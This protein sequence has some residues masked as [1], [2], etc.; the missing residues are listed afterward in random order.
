MVSVFSLLYNF[1]SFLI[2]I[3]STE[4]KMMVDVF[5]DAYEKTFYFIMC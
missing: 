5:F 4:M 3:I 2:R 1:L